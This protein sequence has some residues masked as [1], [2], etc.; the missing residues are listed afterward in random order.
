ML[1]ADAYGGYNKLYEATRTP[2][3]VVQALCWSHGRRKLFELAD[4]AE[5]TSQVEV[6]HGRGHLPRSPWR[7]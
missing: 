4:I 3:R 1:Q 6:R 5:G 7:R 2:R